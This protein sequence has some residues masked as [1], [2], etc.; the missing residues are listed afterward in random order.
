MCLRTT[1]ADFLSLWQNNLNGYI[2]L[3]VVNLLLILQLGEST[4]TDKIPW[5][6]HAKLVI[7]DN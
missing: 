1:P 4:I 7:I 5:D 2:C 3:N 6:S